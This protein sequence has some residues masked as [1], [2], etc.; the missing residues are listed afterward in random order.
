M[1]NWSAFTRQSVS[2]LVARTCQ[3]TRKATIIR[4]PNRYLGYTK[5]QWLDGL[6]AINSYTCVGFIIVS[7][8]AMGYSYYR[9]KK[10]VQPELIRLAEEELRKQKEEEDAM[11]AEGQYQPK[12]SA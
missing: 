9:F 10:S 1:A 11:L 4:A 12:S 8:P 7:I 6:M 2:F 3:S 5:S